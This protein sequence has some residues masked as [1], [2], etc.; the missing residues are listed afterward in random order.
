MVGLATSSTTT[1]MRTGSSERMRKKRPSRHPI[2]ARKTRPKRFGIGKGVLKTKIWRGKNF[3]SPGVFLFFFTL[4]A[5]ESI[6]RNLHLPRVVVLTILDLPPEM[7]VVVFTTRPFS[8]TLSIFLVQS[9]FNERN[10]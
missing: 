10:N 6:K 2:T 8:L 1:T 3:C 9:S 5:E 4:P 7:D